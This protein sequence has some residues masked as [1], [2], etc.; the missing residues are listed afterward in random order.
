MLKKDV[1]IGHSLSGCVG[2]ILDGEV[3][4]HNVLRIESGTCIRSIADLMSVMISYDEHAWRDHTYGV[5]LSVVEQL[6]FDGKL[7]QARISGGKPDLSNG[8]W[9]HATDEDITWFEHTHD[10]EEYHNIE[11]VMVDI[12]GELKDMAYGRHEKCWD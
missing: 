9:T 4:Y 1:V 12:V 8:I 2:D 6:L 10:V 5:A 7:H 3:K 11:D